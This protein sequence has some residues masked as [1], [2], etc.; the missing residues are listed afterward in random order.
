MTQSIFFCQISGAII[1][2]LVWLSLGA[3]VGFPT[4]ALPSLQANITTTHLQ[5]N[6]TNN[7]PNLTYYKYDLLSNKDETI[8]IDPIYLD[9]EMGSW[10]AASFWLSSIPLT[11]LGGYL[12]GLLGRRKIILITHPGALIGW[13]ILATSQN[14]TT[15]FLGRFLSSISIAV[16]VSAVGKYVFKIFSVLNFSFYLVL[17]SK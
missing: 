11:P 12:G 2:S 6:I 8:T 5:N 14:I 15:L 10:F 9:N 3:L 7:S 13:V 4:I 16:H 17:G 1:V